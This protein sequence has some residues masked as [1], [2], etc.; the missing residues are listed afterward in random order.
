MRS[1]HNIAVSKI[2]KFDDFTD[3]E[4]DSPEAGGSTVPEEAYLTFSE[5]DLY[6][7]PKNAVMEEEE[8]PEEAPEE[9]EEEEY[10]EPEEPEDPAIAI[11]AGIIDEAEQ[12]A[13]VILNSA[14]E[15]S[16]RM[17]RDA[18]QKADEMYSAAVEE[19]HGKGYA[20]GFDE[21]GKE[22]R[23]QF[24]RQ[25]EEKYNALFSAIDTACEKIDTQKQEILER[26]LNDL[27]E[28]TLA[29][30]EKIVCIALDSSG[31]VVKRMIL[32]AAAPAGVKQWSKVTISGK[33]ADMMKEDG[34][35]IYEELYAISERIDIITIDDADR[36][37]CFIEFPDQVIDA[38]AGAQL[39]NIKDLIR[40]AD[41][42]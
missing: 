32:Q 5:E 4:Q 23:E 7:K 3:D 20:D 12:R 28:L 33:D 15:V 21:G 38:G 26:N 9:A 41:K 42:E 10:E 27:S 35:D 36:G 34:I 30:A 25:S 31:E 39:R 29:I 11:A 8:P 22:G 37:T 24:L 40:T 6:F 13:K 17:L 2:F 16:E 18:E 1:L 14:G 19:G